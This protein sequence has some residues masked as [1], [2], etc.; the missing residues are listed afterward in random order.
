M[1]VYLVVEDTHDGRIVDE[2]TRVFRQMASAEAY[3]SKLENA[4]PKGSV[5]AILRMQVE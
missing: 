1:I 2:N 5:V 4:L 3:K